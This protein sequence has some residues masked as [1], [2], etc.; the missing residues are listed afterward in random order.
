MGFLKGDLVLIVENE[1]NDDTTKPYVG[2]KGTVLEDSDVP[3]VE[4]DADG[5]IWAFHGEELVLLSRIES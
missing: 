1:H 4:L 3:Y 5:D 2:T